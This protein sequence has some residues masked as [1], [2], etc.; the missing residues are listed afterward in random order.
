MAL[1][2]LVLKG[3]YAG[4]NCVNRFNYV[5]TGTPAAVTLSFALASAAGFIASGEPPVF[6]SS[7]LFSGIRSI[8]NGGIEFNEV[9]VNN[10]YDLT[11]FYTTAFPN[12]TTGTQAGAGAPPF[13]AA[14]FRTNL[15]RRDVA[16]GTKRFA[17]VP[18]EQVLTNGSL[19]TGYVTQLQTLA[20]VMA[21]N[22]EYDDEGNTITFQPVIVSKLKYTTPSGKFAY[23]YYSTLALQLDHIAQG[24][25]WEVYDNARSQTSRQVGHGG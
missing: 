12:D 14:G 18:A 13:V 4:Q 24:I 2:E 23:K 1:F 11:D 7:T 16:R 25:D 8:V 20:D 10:I 15:V 22:L 3:I 17:G 19:A 5:S 9:I 21:S 6:P